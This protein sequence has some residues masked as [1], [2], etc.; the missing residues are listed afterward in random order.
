MRKLGI[1]VIRANERC[2]HPSHEVGVQQRK[3]LPAARLAA[4]SALAA[5][6]IALLGAS[7]PAHV[8][9]QTEPENPGTGLDALPGVH[10]VPLAVQ[11]PGVFGIRLG[12]GYGWTES[13]LEEDDSHQRLQLDGAASVAPLAWLSVSARVLGRYDWHSGDVSDSGVITETR[14]AGRATFP[15]GGS[16]HA[17]SELALRLP[18]GDTVARAFAAVSGDLRLL[19]AYAPERS[20]LRLGL[21]LGLRMDR[22]QYAGGDPERYSAADRLALGVSDTV[23]GALGGVALSYRA[24][25]EWVAEW[26]MQAYFGQI[27]ESPMW[28]RAGARHRPSAAWQLELLLGVSPSQRP[29][30]AEDAPL[31]V[32]EPRLWAGLSATYVWQVRSPPPPVETRAPVEAPVQP[33]VK[34]PPTLRGQVLSPSGT[35]HPGATLTLSQ[36]DSTQTTT[37]DAQGAFTFGPQ[38]PGQYTLNVAAE[39]FSAEPQALDW[40]EGSAEPQITLKRELPRGQIRGTVRRFNGAPVVATVSIKA[41]ELSQQTQA[42]GTFEF[43]VPPGDYSLQVKARGFRPQTRKAHVDLHGVAIVIVELEVAK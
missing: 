31:A 41:L 15:L 14:L 28:F 10:E 11:N 26:A 6:A 27:T 25:L 18:A 20:P 22:S 8:G 36:G 21:A 32:I 1:G 38:A 4:A 40:Q 2:I 24:G 34:P 17:G 43:D 29:S 16:W 39:G 33:V 12:L 5:C 9:A 13:V 7:R 42:D 23:G 35:G 3:R 37:S 19:L 30:L